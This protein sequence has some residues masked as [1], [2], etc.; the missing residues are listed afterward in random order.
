MLRAPS[1]L[2]C[3]SDWG[4]SQC[5]LILQAA[6]HLLEDLNNLQRGTKRQRLKKKVK[7]S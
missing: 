2:F 6:L 1:V 3:A 4:L 7:G 5:V